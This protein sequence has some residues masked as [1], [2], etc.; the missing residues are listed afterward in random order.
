MLRGER[1]VAGVARE[2]AVAIA[3]I[4]IAGGAGGLV[5]A[6]HAAI[7][8]EVA[9]SGKTGHSVAAGHLVEIA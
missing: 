7:A 2:A 8:V 5:E 3:Q 9:Q 6:V 4:E 1:A